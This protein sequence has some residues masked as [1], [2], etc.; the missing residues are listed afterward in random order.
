[1]RVLLAILVGAG[2]CWA[3]PARAQTPTSRDPL[4]HVWTRPWKGVVWISISPLGRR[5]LVIQRKGEAS[6]LND[7]GESLWKKSARGVDR[8]VVASDGRLTALYARRRPAYR[9]VR[10]LDAKGEVVGV[11]E[12]AAPVGN[13]ALTANGDYFVIAAGTQAIFGS[14]DGEKI[15][16]RVIEVGSQVRY[17]LPGPDATVYVSANDPPSVRR[18]RANGEEIWR[19]RAGK[20]PPSIATARDGELVAVGSES[21]EKGGQVRVLL[22]T[23][24]GQPRWQQTEAGRGPRVRI[25][26]DGSSVLLTWER[27]VQYNNRARFE[28]RLACLNSRGQWMWAKG[29]AFTA[30]VCTA[31][32]PRGRWVVGLDMPRRK[33]PRLRLFDQA[34]R[35]LWRHELA[36]RALITAAAADGRTI[37]V[38]QSNDTLTRL[39]VNAGA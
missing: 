7:K 25:S 13:V 36:A 22:L 18:Y 38:Y 6:C 27:R 28:R 15:T 16:T 31:I 35:R 29:G 1:M 12:A 30:P 10:F 19:I 20:R 39:R 8:G 23:A 9:K 4:A 37:I 11:V 33:K 21:D 24:D 17:A 32:D 3:A 26:R 5:I 14:F 34:G 2:I